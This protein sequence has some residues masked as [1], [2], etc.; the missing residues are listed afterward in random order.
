MFSYLIQKFS[1]TSGAD[2]DTANAVKTLLDNGLG[3]FPIKVKPA[4]NNDL[5]SLPKNPPDCPILCNLVFD[6]FILAEEPFAKALQRL[7]Y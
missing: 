6:D 3:T 7:L 4:F 2:A 1:F 5:K